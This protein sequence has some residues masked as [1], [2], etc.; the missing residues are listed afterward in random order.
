MQDRCLRRIRSGTMLSGR[1]F[2]PVVSYNS[3]NFFI[4]RPVIC[5]RDTGPSRTIRQSSMRRGAFAGV[6]PSRAA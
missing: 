1:V 3:P 2:C 6:A 5:R 4:G